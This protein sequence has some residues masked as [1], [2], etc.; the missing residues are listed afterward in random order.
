MDKENCAPP[1][2]VSASAPL[3]NDMGIPDKQASDQP[4]CEQI[5]PRLRRVGRLYELDGEEFRRVVG[6]PRL[7]RDGLDVAWDL[8]EF[9]VMAGAELPDDNLPDEP[10]RRTVGQAR[11][12]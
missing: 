11:P 5:T 7:D 2:R 4:W 8:R 12:R 6:R 3:T 1:A 9:A 10:V